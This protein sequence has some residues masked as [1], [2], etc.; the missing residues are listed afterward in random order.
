MVEGFKHTDIGLIPDDWDVK[1]FQDVTKVITCGLAATPKYVDASIGK[2]FL[3]AQNVQ[4]GKVVYDK[5]RHVPKSLFD[6]ITKH[7]PPR[8]G[9]LLYTRVGAGIGEAGVIEEEFEFAIYVSLTLIKVD[10]T[11]IHNY[12]LLHLLNSPKYKFLAKNGQFA[13]A[14]V[15]N[16]NVN[17]VREFPIPLPPTKDEQ[18]AIATA[19]ND[20]DTLIQKL[21]QLIAKK[22][23]IKTGAMQELLK[24]K[25]GWEE[26]TLGEIADV[27]GGGTPSTFNASYWNG[28]INWFTPTE[29][30]DK[31]YS[32]ESIRKITHEGLMSSSAKLLPVGTILLTSRASIG[33]ASI[34]KVESCTNQ[35]FQSL[36]VKEDNS[37]EFLYYLI[38]TLKQIML[39][40]ASGSTFL[41]IS[42]SKLKSIEI[43]IPNPTEQTRIAQILSDM[44][45]EIQEL[46]KQLEKNKMMKQGMMQSLLTG[47]IRLI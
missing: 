34:L 2:P 44:D 8:K 22:R 24:P 46:E 43:S 4:N 26:K 36:I 37:N 13:G 5:F 12:Y 31:K 27:V 21:E 29:I 7:N 32:F 28:N 15:Q 35:G 33:D 41:E 11:I 18:T 20:A 23:N 16:L 42:P 10:E 38:L 17:V 45:N 39:Q 40:N 3:S 25:V 19:L 6:L 1:R 14:G 47:K 30:G 9:D